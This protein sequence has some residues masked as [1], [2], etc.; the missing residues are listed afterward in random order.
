MADKRKFQSWTEYK[1]FTHA[2]KNNKTDRVAAMAEHYS[3]NCMVTLIIPGLRDRRFPVDIAMQYANKKT[4][5]ALI[6]NGMSLHTYC[7]DSYNSAAP[8][9]NPIIAAYFHDREDIATYLMEKYPTKINFNTCFKDDKMRLA[10]FFENEGMYQLAKVAH[11]AEISAHKKRAEAHLKQAE[12][13]TEKANNAFKKAADL[14]KIIPKN[15]IN[16]RPKPTTKKLHK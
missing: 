1:S 4:C 12:K 5:D 2:I 3:S 8:K 11:H 10:D 14:E 16:K 13:F 7:L 6:E 15:A 9:M